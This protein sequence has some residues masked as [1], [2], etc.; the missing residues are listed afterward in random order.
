MITIKS[1]KVRWGISAVLALLILLG[2]YR[3]VFS[4]AA[5]LIFGMMLV[6]CDKETNLQQIF[7]VMPMAN[8]FKLA[9]GVQSFFTIIIL[10]Y[11]VLH[12]VLPR[13]AT[14]VV[15]MFSAY[16][17]ISQLWEGNFDLFRTIKLICNLLFLSSTLNG[18]VRFKHKDIFLS[19]IVGNILSSFFGMMDSQ[20]FKIQSYVGAKALS[21]G[22]GFGDDIVRFAGLYID[23]NYYSIGLIISLC[24]VVILYHR[25]EINSFVLLIFTVPLVYFLVMTYSKSAII[26][27]IVPAF[28]FVYSSMRKHKRME[29]GIF[30]ATVSILAVLIVAEKIPAMNIIMTRLTE[31]DS[32][33]L[34]LNEATTGRFDLWITYSKYIFKNIGTALFGRGIGADLLVEHASHNTYIDIIYFLGAVGGVL[35]LTSLGIILKQSVQTRVKRNSMNYS[36]MICIGIMYFFLGE[37]FYF[38][39]PFQIFIA[40]MVLNLPLGVAKKSESKALLESEN[41]NSKRGNSLK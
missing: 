24:L 1:E 33:N 38:D 25:D 9:P 41:L 12:L 39:P 27:L 28:F 5:F 14:T 30:F 29:L 36:V 10:V 40:F 18:E 32:E 23:P 13:Q 35:L 22:Y 7:F 37:L 17:V 4:L 8:I 26:M 20:L 34:D 19:F 2:T 21:Q 16:I 15:V 11:V 3:N 6:F 31:I